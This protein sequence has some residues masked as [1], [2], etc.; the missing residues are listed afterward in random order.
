MTTARVHI[1][2]RA[3]LEAVHRRECGVASNER[4]FYAD[5][6]VQTIRKYS[7]SWVKILR[8]IRW[9]D[10]SHRPH[11]QAVDVWNG[12]PVHHQSGGKGFVERTER[13]DRQQAI[14]HGRH[15]HRRPRITGDRATAIAR[16]VVVRH[17]GRHATHSTRHVSR[18]PRRDERRMEFF[19]RHP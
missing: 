11:F 19:G 13:V 9:H 15:P 6:K 3:A 8:Y 18:Q 4:P 5:Q 17:M 1:V 2:S 14:Q 16:G 7:R 10:Q 12:H